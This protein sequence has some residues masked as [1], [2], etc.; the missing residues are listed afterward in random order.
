MAILRTRSR[1]IERAPVFEVDIHPGRFDVASSGDSD[2]PHVSI[3]AMVDTGSE[4][5]VIHPELVDELKL[6]SFGPSDM[7]FVGI[8]G[9]PPTPAPQ[10]NVRLAFQNSFYEWNGMA[11]ALPFKVNRQKHRNER[12]ACLIGRQ[13]L[14]FA[15]FVYQGENNSYSLSFKKR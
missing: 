10:Y 5:T 1:L 12:L 4:V 13:A 7:N 9:G 15:T 11:V 2:R 3:M 8:Y 6:E 14:Q